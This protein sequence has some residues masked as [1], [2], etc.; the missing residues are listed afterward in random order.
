MEGVVRVKC[1]KIFLVI[2]ACLCIILL[3][4]ACDSSSKPVVNYLTAVG[5]DFENSKKDLEIFGQEYGDD[6]EGT[7]KAL[8]DIRRAKAEFQTRME[9]VKSQEVPSQPAELKNFHNQL[10]RYYEDTLAIL[11]EYEMIFA[12]NEELMKSVNPMVEK[13]ESMDFGGAPS[14]EEI[15]SE[16]KELKETI[17]Q[18]ITAMEKC[19]PPDYLKYFHYD[20]VVIMKSLSGAVDDYIFALQLTD[21]LRMNANEYR[22]VQLSNRMYHLSDESYEDIKERTEKLEEAGEKA[23]GIQ[24][25]LYRQLLRWQG[26]YKVKNQ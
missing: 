17:D 4:P 18:A 14:I 3:L 9:K 7:S 24:E 2:V 1:K 26:E 8:E 23:V 12:Y 5:P 21:P 22:V 13:A 25:E 16:M 15:K 19:T 6:L 20:F 11:N 10:I